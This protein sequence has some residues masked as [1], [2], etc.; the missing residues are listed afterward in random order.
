M[1]APSLLLEVFLY[2]GKLWDVVFWVLSFL[3]FIYKVRLPPFQTVSPS[4]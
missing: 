2:F 1:A 4:V 3:I